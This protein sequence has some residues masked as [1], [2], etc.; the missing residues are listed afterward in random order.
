MPALGGAKDLKRQEKTLQLTKERKERA[1]AESIRLAESVTTLQQFMDAVY[2]EVYDAPTK[3][4]RI[5]K[6]YRELFPDFMGQAVKCIKFIERLEMLYDTS[7][8]GVKYA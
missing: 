1:E 8:S 6:K 2:G 3:H 4:K 7:S 5:L